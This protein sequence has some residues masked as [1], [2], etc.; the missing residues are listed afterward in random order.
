MKVKSVYAWTW[1]FDEGELCCFAEAS[2]K[3]LLEHP[4]AGARAVRVKMA[5]S[6]IKRARTATNTRKP[7]RLKRSAGRTAS[8]VR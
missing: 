2:R 6:P 3:F 8:A 4:M 5:Y 7:K 1:L